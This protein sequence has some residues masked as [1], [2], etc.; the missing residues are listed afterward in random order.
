MRKE[1]EITR[2]REQKK[3]RRKFSKERGGERWKK[4]TEPG[5]WNDPLNVQSQLGGCRGVI[6]GVKRLFFDSE[7]L[8]FSD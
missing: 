2:K 5:S 3:R 4:N 1:F 8:Q 6:I 7:S